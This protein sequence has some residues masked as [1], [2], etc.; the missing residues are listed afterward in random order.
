M[1]QQINNLFNLQRKTELAIE[2]INSGIINDNLKPKTL[3][4]KAKVHNKTILLTNMLTATGVIFT[5]YLLT[6]FATK[7]YV[8]KKKLVQAVQNL[9]FSNLECHYYQA[10][11]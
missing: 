5:D 11:D 6:Y 9:I 2:I 3:T 7:F 8:E 10:P 1:G 4:S